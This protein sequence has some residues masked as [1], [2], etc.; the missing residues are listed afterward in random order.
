MISNL[1]KAKILV[2]ALPFIKKYHGKTI[3]IKYGGSAMV[4]EIARDQF[5]QDVVLMK[6]VGINPVIIHG[7]GPEINDMLNR[8]GKESKFVGGNRVT[9]EETMEIVEMVLS[10]KVN[11]GIVSDINKYGGKAVGL[12]GKDDNMILVEKKYIEIEGKKV[13][14]GF[15]GEIKKVNDSVI[16]LLE[17][18]DVI[19]VISSIGVDKSGN[20]Y[21]INADYVAGAIAGKL[22][23]DRLIFLTDVDGI[24]L[25]PFNK[26]TLIDEATKEEVESLIRKN[27]ISGG[28]LPKVNTCLDAIKNGVDNVIILNGK[29]EHSL[30]LELFTVEGAGT[31]IKKGD[32]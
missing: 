6:Y 14:I 23:A 16:R 20:T 4:N 9:D 18:N 21:N 32:D 26:E 3:V 22:K 27:I 13:D 28:M 7:G 11:K 1:D 10:G 17:S 2:K 5:I 30:L 31:L 12:S 19:P 8:V 15:V 29:L 25:D 24:M